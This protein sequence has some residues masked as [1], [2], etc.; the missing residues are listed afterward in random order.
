M[1]H[2]AAPQKD[3]NSNR[4]LCEKRDDDHTTSEYAIIIPPPL[5]S[6]KI[7]D[8]TERKTETP[9]GPLVTSIRRVRKGT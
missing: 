7:S 5:P 4:K 2:T 8:I 6:T 1:L 3:L 9:S